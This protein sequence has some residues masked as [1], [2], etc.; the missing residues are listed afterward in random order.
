MISPTYLYL[1]D[2]DFTDPMTFLFIY[3]DE[4]VFLLESWPEMTRP[5]STALTH[6]DHFDPVFPI[7]H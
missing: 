7:S 2:W 1:I 3:E 4:N 6:L 5:I